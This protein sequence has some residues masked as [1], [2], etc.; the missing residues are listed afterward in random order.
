MKL[1]DRNVSQGQKV[2]AHLID[3][4]PA[5]VASIDCNMVP[6]YANKPFKTWFEVSDAVYGASFPAIVGKQV[7]NQVQQHLGK[8]VVGGPTH[9]QISIPDRKGFLYLDINLS[10]EKDE[11]GEVKGFIFH[12]S[13]ITEKLRTQRAL[14]D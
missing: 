6:Q 1:T 10:P 5:L 4:I 9:F 2:L 7:F 12:G 8:V 3:S 14:Q 13:D 11:A